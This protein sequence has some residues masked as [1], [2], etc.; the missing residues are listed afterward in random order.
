MKTDVEEWFEEN[1]EKLDRIIKHEEQIVQ[2]YEY[3]AAKQLLWATW[4]RAII[5]LSGFIVALALIYD[6]A[7]AWFTALARGM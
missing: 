4:R 5:A 3:N 2:D 7:K 6:T 1:R